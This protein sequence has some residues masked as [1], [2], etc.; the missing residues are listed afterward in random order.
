MESRIW[1]P[2]RNEKKNRPVN[3]ETTRRSTLSNQIKSKSARWK[4]RDPSMG[5]T[6]ESL[7]G[8]NYDSSISSKLVFMSAAVKRRR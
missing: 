5:E 1:T 8:G 6:R 2:E 7:L 4:L 3:E